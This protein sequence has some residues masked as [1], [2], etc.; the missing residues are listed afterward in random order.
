MVVE[1][2]NKYPVVLNIS[3]ETLNLS[4]KTTVGLFEE[5]IPIRKSGINL[6][7]GFNARN[8][9]D[10]LKAVDTE[11][12][13]M[14]FKNDTQACRINGTDYTFLVMPVRIKV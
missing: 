8:L 9:I 13:E 1:K 12:I 7:I 14:T 2:E 5:E 3:N 4:V 6:T 11:K 10:S